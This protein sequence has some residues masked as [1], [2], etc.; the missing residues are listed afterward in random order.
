MLKLIPLPTIASW[1]KVTHPIITSSK[2]STCTSESVLVLF[3]ME[4]VLC[5]GACMG[6][7]FAFVMR[8]VLIPQ[9]CFCYCWAV[10][11]QSFLLTPPHQWGSW[12]CTRIW[13]GKQLEQLP[14]ADHRAV[15]YHVMSCLTT[16]AWE[17]SKGERTKWW[18]LSS[19]AIIMCDGPLLPWRWLNMCPVMESSELFFF[20]CVQLLLYLLNC[21]Y[22]IAWV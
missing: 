10:L 6:Q 11:A 15:L 3:E 17:R 18:C 13:E 21:L 12:E 16:K 7:C 19:Q 14:P 9:E 5:I 1:H 8:T 2:C 4:L 22:L 20:A